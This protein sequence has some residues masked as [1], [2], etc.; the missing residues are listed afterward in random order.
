[1]VEPKLIAEDAELDTLFR[2]AVGSAQVHY[3]ELLTALEQK[4]ISTTLDQTTVRKLIRQ[5]ARSVLPNATETRIV[6][7]GNYRSWRHFIGLRAT[8]AADP[9]IR[10]LAVALL[11]EL[12]KVAPDVFADFV[13]STLD[14]NSEIA[15]TSI[16]PTSGIDRQ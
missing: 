2:S 3:E 9:E 13:I 14:D 6:V 11:R 4:F 1:V 7:T 5:A 15:T 8:K 10:I 12:R 16:M